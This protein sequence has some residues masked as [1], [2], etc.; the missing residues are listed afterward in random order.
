MRIRAGRKG[1]TTRT[2]RGRTVAVVPPRACKGRAIEAGATWVRANG[3]VG[4]LT[5]GCERA[6]VAVTVRPRV[7]GRGEGVR[8][9]R[10]PTRR[11]LRANGRGRAPS[12]HPRAQ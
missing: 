10:D 12:P 3:R 8:A 5:R 7:R 2:A 9:G 1:G 4:A 11:G 6:P